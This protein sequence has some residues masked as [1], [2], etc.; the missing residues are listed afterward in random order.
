M[1]SKHHPASRI[2]HMHR[3]G[4]AAPSASSA[5]PGVSPG[6]TPGNLPSN[7]PNGPV[8]SPVANNTGPIDSDADMPESA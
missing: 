7:V 5:A 8:T 4:G 1:S 2:P 6:T 3:G